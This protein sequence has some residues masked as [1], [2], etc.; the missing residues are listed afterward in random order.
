MANTSQDFIEAEALTASILVR[1]LSDCPPDTIVMLGVMEIEAAVP[2]H[3]VYT[4]TVTHQV[5]GQRVPAFAMTI[6]IDKLI[7]LGRR[8]A[9]WKAR[10]EAAEK[11]P[12][13]S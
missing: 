7:E 5:T 4:L 6:N 9:E 2:V 13:L 1:S 12:R 10:R 11:D 3:E 8:A